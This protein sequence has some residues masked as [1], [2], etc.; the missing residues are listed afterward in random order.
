MSRPSSAATVFEPDANPIAL[1]LMFAG[2]G[3]VW[4]GLIVTL[5]GRVL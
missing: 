5:V 2:T 4:V 3:L 1:A